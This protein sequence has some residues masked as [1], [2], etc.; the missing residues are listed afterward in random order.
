[1]ISS[2]FWRIIPTKPKHGDQNKNKARRLRKGKI[3][4]KRKEEAK[5]SKNA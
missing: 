5:L 2:F 1:L 4:E 3:R